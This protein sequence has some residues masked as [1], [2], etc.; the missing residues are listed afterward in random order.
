MLRVTRGL[1][2]GAGRQKTM[3]RLRAGLDRINRRYDE[4]Q[5]TQV[6]ETVAVVISRWLR[7]AGFYGISALDALDC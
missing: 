7:A 3:E 4:A 2:Q 6:Q 5:D 1:R